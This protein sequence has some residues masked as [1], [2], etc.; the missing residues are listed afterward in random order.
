MSLETG[1]RT[2]SSQEI[3]DDFSRHIRQ[4]AVPPAEALGQPG[5]IDAELMQNGRVPVIDRDRVAHHVVAELVGGAVDVAAL[6]PPARHPDG[7]TTGMMIPAVIP[8]QVALPVGG[9]AELA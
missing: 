2:R 4:V 7:E 8:G 3:L 1:S 6:E 9:A 5:V